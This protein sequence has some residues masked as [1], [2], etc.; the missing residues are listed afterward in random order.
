VAGPPPNGSG[1]P[2]EALYGPPA[3]DY[4]RSHAIDPRLAH[5]LGVR[6][7]DG[8]IVYCCTDAKGAFERVRR[9][10]GRGPKLKGPRRPLACWWPR[11][12]PDRA[13]FVLI[14]EGE[15]DALAAL[16]AIGSA[17]G[18]ARSVLSE[19]TVVCVPGT[20][21]PAARL[22]EELTRVGA[23]QALLAMDGDEA[24]AKFTASASHSLAN[25]G[26]QAVPVSLPRGS[27]L[28]DCL[29]SVGDPADWL[30]NLIADSE[31]RAEEI[32]REAPNDGDSDTGTRSSK[33]PPKAQRLVDLAIE[34]AEF[35]HDPQRRPWATV[36]VADHRRTIALDSRDFTHW[37]GHVAHLDGITPKQALADAIEH[38]KSEALYAGPQRTVH[39]RL[40]AG[41]G[42]VYLD[43]GD[44]QWRAV[45]I[46]AGSWRLLEGEPPVKFR[47]PPSMQALPEPLRPG[48][49]DALRPFVNLSDEHWHLLVGWLVGCFAPSGP[50]PLLVLTGEQG[51][52]KSTTAWMLRSLIDPAWPEHRALPESERDLMIAATNA[53]VVAFDNLSGLGGRNAWISDALCRLSTGGGYATRALYSNDEEQLFDVQRPAILNGIDALPH[54]SDLLSRSLPIELARL[55]EHQVQTE[56]DL[57]RSFA[58]ARPRV[59]AGLLD[60]AACALAHVDE[61]H[62]P[63]LPRMADHVVW[64]TAASGA[65]GWDETT[66]SASYATSRQDTTD[67]ALEAS[68]LWPHLATLADGTARTATELLEALETEA[69]ADV[70]RHPRWPRDPKA[71]GTMLTRLASDLRQRGIEIERGSEGRGVG[72]KKTIKLWRL[73][74]PIDPIDPTALQSQVSGPTG[75]DEAPAGS[76]AGVDGVDAGSIAA[77]PETPATMRL[78]SMGSMGSMLSL[79][80]EKEEERTA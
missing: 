17:T 57:R 52:G 33:A 2:P 38:L 78:G 51:S 37:L 9:L 4:F 25:A 36:P 59:L 7:R 28:S 10:D 42:V 29:A 56:R 12:R 8:A 55:L 15:S 13:E 71:L 80:R 14:S 24:G 72:R 49:V 58:A 1:A 32:S 69:G 46:S 48:S 22:A 61:V 67:A 63:A 18:G 19:V 35:F 44:E 77:E 76:I 40:A 26:I 60:A 74:D 20:G 66:Y 39:T 45:E 68:P 73:V 41:D 11:G 50:Y 6:E 75:V 43:L 70:T 21:F 30:A 31:A 62:P 27:D 3:R 65:L 34:G 16:S 54:R 79:N 64:V 47:R 5:E 53:R 23:R